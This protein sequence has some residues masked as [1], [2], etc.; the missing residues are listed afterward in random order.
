MFTSWSPRA[1]QFSTPQDVSVSGWLD[2]EVIHITS[3]KAKDPATTKK[4]DS[5]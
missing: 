2:G 4:S 5:N 1:K 3:I